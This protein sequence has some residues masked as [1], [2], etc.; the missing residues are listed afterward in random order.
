MTLI[1][2]SKILLIFRSNS[3]IRE[4]NRA[5]NYLY[6]Q[7]FVA[8][9]AFKITQNTIKYLQNNRFF[10]LLFMFN[11]KMQLMTQCATLLNCF[12]RVN[13]QSIRIHKQFFHF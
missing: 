9:L 4:T 5:N 3:V 13:T 10:F 11:D 7:Q 6:C 1:Y 12:D 2:L 8:N